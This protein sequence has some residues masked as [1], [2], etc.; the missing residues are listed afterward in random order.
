[1]SPP[2]SFKK[3][4]PVAVAI[5][6]DGGRLAPVRPPAPEPVPTPPNPLLVWPNELLAWVA[7][8]Q[9]HVPLGNSTAIG[10]QNLDAEIKASLHL[11]NLQPALIE[12]FLTR[13]RDQLNLEPATD[14]KGVNSE[15]VRYLCTALLRDGGPAD[16]GKVVQTLQKDFAWLK[17][18]IRSL[19][20]RLFTFLFQTRFFDSGQ[21]TASDVRALDRL[22]DL[23]KSQDT[24]LSLHPL[25]QDAHKLRELS[26]QLRADMQFYEE[27]VD[28]VDKF[29][30]IEALIRYRT[31]LIIDEFAAH[32]VSTVI[33]TGSLSYVTTREFKRFALPVTDEGKERRSERHGEAL[34]Q[35]AAAQKRLWAVTGSQLKHHLFR[36]IDLYEVEN[37]NYFHRARVRDRFEE[38]LNSARVGRGQLQLLAA[39][40]KGIHAVGRRMVY[41]EIEDEMDDPDAW[42]S[43]VR[44]EISNAPMDRIWILDAILFDMCG[45][46]EIGVRNYLTPFGADF[47]KG[48]TIDME[49]DVTSAEALEELEAADPDKSALYR[50]I[51]ERADELDKEFLR[52]YRKYE[53]FVQPNVALDLIEDNLRLRG[54][55]MNSKDESP[56]QKEYQ[57]DLQILRDRR[58]DAQD[59]MIYTKARRT[60]PTRLEELIVEKEY[61]ERVE[62]SDR[63]FTFLKRQS[64]RTWRAWRDEREEEGA[65]GDEGA[66]GAEGDARV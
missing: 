6:R 20:A 27:L 29:L 59:S 2:E 7:P 4:A 41:S 44:F 18:P 42:R 14:E 5:R 38:C 31:G 45:E 24:R 16:V 26:L 55:V 11:A 8:S 65:E 56:S 37:Q 39:I 32:I 35:I 57:K 10:T 50:A 36:A 12:F 46:H 13:M 17:L 33:D 34:E 53:R 49:F 19:D 3:T 23:T 63:F 52:D 60:A 47:D 58:K 43:G 66:E 28:Y 1:M 15:R 54:L 40:A 61:P 22:Q 25:F 21:Y 62:D 64:E 51:K 48:T 9:R 30:K